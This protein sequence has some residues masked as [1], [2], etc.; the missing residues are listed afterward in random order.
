MSN[1]CCRCKKNHK[2]KRELFKHE[3]QKHN[4]FQNRIIRCSECSE[5]FERKTK[6]RILAKN[7]I[8]QLDTDDLFV[9]LMAVKATS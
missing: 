2:S 6:R 7:I 5:N 1:Y 4:I 8:I 9:V 3:R